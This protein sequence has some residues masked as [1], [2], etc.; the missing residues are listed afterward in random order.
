V[1][2]VA[3]APAEDDPEDD[4]E[5]DD[6]DEKPD[7][8]KELKGKGK[9]ARARVRERAR[10]RAILSSEHAAKNP[11]IA[12]QL[13]LQTAMPRQVAIAMLE[14]MPKGTT[15][16]DARMAAVAR[17]A[18]GGGA[19]HEPGADSRAIAG[20]WDTAFAKVAPKGALVANDTRSNWD[21]SMRSAR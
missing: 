1:Q 15:G 14:A 2:P 3:V 5:D 17:P 19:A 4:P 7:S 8:E 9:K 18:I 11:E 16:L 20:A 13:A 12:M 6:K 21:R 10:C